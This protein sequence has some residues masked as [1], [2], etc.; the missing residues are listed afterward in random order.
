MENNN[1]KFINLTGHIVRLCTKLE[2]KEV[3]VIEELQPHQKEVKIKDK[4]INHM[5]INYNGYKIPITRIEEKKCI[6]L[7]QPKEN[8][9]YIVSRSIREHMSHRLDLLSP[10]P[11]GT[12]HTYGSVFGTQSLLSNY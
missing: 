12:I 2:N 5:V 4:T 6:N 8:T 7:P 9:F 11:C 3:L 10:D 1:I